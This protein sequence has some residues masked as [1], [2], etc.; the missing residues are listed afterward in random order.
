MTTPTHTHACHTGMAGYADR[1]VLLVMHVNIILMAFAHEHDSPLDVPVLSISAVPCRAQ[2]AVSVSGSS[3][4]GSIM[5]DGSISISASESPGPS[6]LASSNGGSAAAG[7]VPRPAAALAQSPL[8][9]SPPATA[10]ARPER[11]AAQSPPAQQGALRTSL[12]ISAAVAP[13]L[14]AAS[15]AA[16]SSANGAS[17]VYDSMYD[18]SDVSIVSSPAVSLRSGRA[19]AELEALGRCGMSPNSADRADSCS[20]LGASALDSSSEDCSAGFSRCAP[21]PCRSWGCAYMSE[22]LTRIACVGVITSPPRPVCSIVR[23][24]SQRH[25][26]GLGISGFQGLPWQCS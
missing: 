10:T 11:T 16:S 15:E 22:Q 13:Q 9:E 24:A 21:R 5:S 25:N 14:R 3:L 23:A 7:V 19:G 20:E 2:S 26:V 17:S 8:R 4:S 18:G 6:Q 12:K 1:L